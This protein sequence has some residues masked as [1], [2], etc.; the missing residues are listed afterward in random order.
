MKVNQVGYRADAPAKFAYLGMWLGAAGPADFSAFAGKPFKLY[1]YQPGAHWDEGKA[2]GEPVFTGSIK[3]RMKDADQRRNDG[4]ITGEDVYEMDFGPFNRPGR[5]CVV[6]PGLG[7]SWPFNIGDDAYG[8]AFYTVMRALY[9]QRCGI[10]LKQPYTAWTRKACHTTTYRGGFPPETDRWYDSDNYA[11]PAGPGGAVKFGF[12]DERDHPLK[13]GSFAAV[14][15]TITPDKVPVT[16]GWHDA[17]DYDRRYYHYGVVW[18]LCGLYEMFPT[19]FTDGQ[20]NIP[21]SGNGVPD[22]L[23]EAAVQVDFFR[24]TQLPSGGVSGWVEQPHHPSHAVAPD[25]DDTPFST[26]LPERTSSY[27]YAASAAYLGRLIAPFDAARSRGY[28]ESAAKAYAWA[29]DPKNTIRNVT[30]NLPG[31]KA[32]DA[33]A[34]VRFDQKE[35]LK[36]SQGTKA[37]ADHML[38]AAQLYAATGDKRYLADWTDHQGIEVLLRGQPDAVPPFAFVTPGLH[39][40]WFGADAVDKLK[41]VAK[42]ESDLYAEG[43]EQLAYRTLWYAPTHAYYA[44][45]AWGHV[46]AGYKSRYPIVAWRLTGEDKYRR[47]VLLALDW[48]LGCNEMGRALVTGVG[49]THPV[50]LQHITSERDEWLEPVPGI[51]PYTFTYGVAYPAWTTQFGLVDPGHGSVKSF[52]PGAAVCLLPAALGREK[53]QAQM[54]AVP[55]TGNWQPAAVDAMRPALGPAYP[56]MRRLYTHPTLVPGQNEFTVSETISPLAAACG[57]MLSDGWKPDEPTKSRKPINDPRD[58]PIYLQP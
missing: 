53:V 45:M 42:R 2:T 15:A 47:C 19:R 40:E 1:V 44:H 28:V 32:G 48:Q 6:V 3:L 12:R 34:V 50:C 36:E 18:D 16:G 39:P 30:F 17:A 20:L 56:L 26:S 5:Y 7:R 58:L 43:Q 24:K 27:A 46:H 13:V 33:P 52:F 23:D 8:P 54:D 41:A 9:Q 25:R 55:R 14:G 4:R 49:S 31:G 51:P 37:N 57:A 29:S 38:A 10:E 35:R 21:E 11:G 22:L